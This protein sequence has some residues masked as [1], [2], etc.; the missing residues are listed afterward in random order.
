MFYL[1][2]PVLQLLGTPY[3]IDPDIPFSV[4]SDVQFVCKYLQAYKNVGSPRGIDRKYDE[5][6][7]ELVKFSTDPDLEDDD[8]HKLLH[9]YMPNHI[10]RSKIMQQL[11]IRCTTG[12][13]VM[14]MLLTVSPK[15]MT[16]VIYR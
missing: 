9:E 16:I 3:E 12:F 2:V 13:N 5:E 15:F 11:F 8:C 4:D 1:E 6:K 10:T 7:E 14:H